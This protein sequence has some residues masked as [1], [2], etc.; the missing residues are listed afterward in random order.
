MNV[1]YKLTGIS[2]LLLHSGQAI[3]PSNQFAKA[4]KS[5]SKKRQK[6]DDDYATLSRIE[7]HSGLYH[8]GAPDKIED[9]VP[10]VDKDARVIIPALSIEAMVVAGGKKLK[11]G[12]AVKSGIIV[13]EDA[14]LEYEG[15]TDINKLWA[16][17][18]HIHKVAAKVGTAR[19][20]RTRPIFRV[21]GCGITIT[22]DETVI[23]EA[24]VF[25]ILK[26]AGQLVGIGDWR[27]RFGRFSVERA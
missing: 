13:E 8:N 14:I 11:Q 18:K 2:P 20:M 24:E 25:Q 5:A 26:T 15:P 17:A 21:W 7:W 10:S 16:G 27:P 4:M 9:G 3:D 19:I 1:S 23:D 22:A 6:T 12:N